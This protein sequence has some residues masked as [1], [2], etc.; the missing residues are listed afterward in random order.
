MAANANTATMIDG[1]AT[2]QVEPTQWLRDTSS[3]SRTL[4]SQ[5]DS[6]G[7]SWAE[8]SKSVPARYRVLTQLGTGGTGIVYKVTDVE[9]GEIVALK[10]LKP[11]IASDV[12]MQQ[13][14]RKEVCLARKVTHKNVCRIHEFNR[15]NGTVCLSMEFV[16]GENLLSKLRRVGRLSVEES[17]GIA[18]QIC[19][20]LGEA[21]A[22]GIIHRD[23]KPANIML[24]ASGVVKIMDF[25]I[26]RLS[27]GN[28]QM[29]GTIAGT[30]AYMAP[31]QVQLRPMGPRADIYALGL[32][33][34]E[35]VTGTRAF[36]GDSSIAIA[37]KQVQENP[38]RPCEVVPSLPA[39]IEA[40]ILKCL[41]KDPAKRFPSVAEVCAAL[42]EKQA[43]SGESRRTVSLEF[44]L[45]DIHVQRAVDYSVEKARAAGPHLAAFAADVQHG[46]LEA[47]RFAS[48]SIE[49]ARTF[50]RAHDLRLPK[51]SRR[52]S[53]V[54]ILSI[55]LL[56]S[57][58]T[59]GRSA[60]MKNHAMTVAPHDFP[61]VLPLSQSAELNVMPPNSEAVT[62]TEVDLSDSKGDSKIA[63][64]TEAPRNAAFGDDTSP[65]V[66]NAQVTVRAKT[67]SI[68]EISTPLPSTRPPLQQRKAVSSAMHV[69]AKTA[70]TQKIG[71]AV[72]EVAAALPVATPVPAPKLP[73]TTEEKKTEGSK[74]EP[75]ETFL[76]VGSFKDANWADKAIEQLSKLGFH[77]VS[78]HKTHLW[79]QSYH[80]MVGPYSTATDTDAARASLAELHFK[81][82]AAK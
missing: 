54:A 43:A 34:Y 66:A 20:G 2:R 80:V 69:P 48:R 65:T 24:D 7:I 6:S 82:Q 63:Q 17:L 31:E 10:V 28:G 67:R 18:R 23:L 25:G 38:K 49:A 30:P 33:M 21:H 55:V 19:A 37:L 27:Q 59:Y 39:N 62:T 44:R 68:S 81:S 53:A 16:E 77:A 73:D 74:P 57:V 13:S 79:M 36:E 75:A 70:E 51:P 14:L 35:M 41:Q 46:T 45:P 50:V 1:H 71:P 9:T 64:E 5:G 42:Q 11:G 47:T 72:T 78:V 8:I 22:Q 32:V 61:Q 26:A 40:V 12:D 15:S 58:F 56:G 52:G 3:N 29:T 60:R 4:S 76:E